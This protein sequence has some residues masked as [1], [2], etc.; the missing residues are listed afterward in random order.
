MTGK[1]LEASVAK[2]S[3]RKDCRPCRLY[4]GANSKSRT[5]KEPGQ[6]WDS[7]FAVRDVVLCW[8]ISMG[9]WDRQVVVMTKLQKEIAVRNLNLVLQ[10]QRSADQPW[11]SPCRCCFG[12]SLKSLSTNLGP[13]VD[14]LDMTGRAFPESPASQLQSNIPTTTFDLQACSPLIYLAKGNI[15]FEFAGI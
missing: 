8:Q 12:G 7:K 3:L 15:A 5:E 4:R 2:R 6:R 13:C 9:V 11:C 14:V 10:C 1:C